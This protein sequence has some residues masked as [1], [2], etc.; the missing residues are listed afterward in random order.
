M[1][2]PFYFM[3]QWSPAYIKMFSGG[4]KFLLEVLYVDY[5]HHN[6][7]VPVQNEQNESLK[8]EAKNIHVKNICR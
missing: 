8:V 4:H 3:L 6:K 5:L 7:R 2:G 1:H